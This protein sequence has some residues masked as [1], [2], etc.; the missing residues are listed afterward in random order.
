MQ[1]AR[2]GLP[3]GFRRDCDGV[4][5]TAILACMRRRRVP[6]IRSAAY[7]VEMRSCEVMLM[8]SMWRTERV[9]PDW[10]SMEVAHQGHIV[11]PLP[12]STPPIENETAGK[13]NMLHRWVLMS[14]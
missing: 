12:A 10:V 11:P 2:N 5:H 7:P 3:G 8:N 9:N 13:T 14:G 1:P 4:A 6:N